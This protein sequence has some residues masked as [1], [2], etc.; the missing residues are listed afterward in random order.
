MLKF[1]FIEK[2]LGVIFPPHF[3]YDL[4]NEDRKIEKW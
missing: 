2:G 4:K 1:D 3:V